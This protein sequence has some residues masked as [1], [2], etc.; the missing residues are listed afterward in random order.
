MTQL[1]DSP[2]LRAGNPLYQ[3]KPKKLPFDDSSEWDDGYSAADCENHHF[4]H[5]VVTALYFTMMI[6]S[7]ALVYTVFVVVRELI[8]SR[9]LKFN[10]TGT[11]L[12]ILFVQGISVALLSLIYFANN[13]GLDRQE[14]WYQ[15]R[16]LLF[17]V[18]FPCVPLID[19][20]IAVTW[21]DLYDRTNKMSKS[22]SKVI[23]VMR[24]AFRLISLFLA[25]GMS[26]VVGSGSLAALVWGLIGPN[27]IGW[28]FVAVGGLL[29]TKTLCPD[30][31]DVANPNWKVSQAIRR[32]VSH[33]LLGKILEVTLL[34]GMLTVNRHPQ[35]GYFYGAF[36]GFYIFTFVF[37]M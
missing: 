20:E 36:T 34:L 8:R 16:T 37:R 1:N 31:K 15:R 32:S 2:S 23:K 29:I 28:P 22:S 7:L 5:F 6:L 35:L 11:S 26:F 21:M 18:M 25:F 4:Q 27:V 3:K 24:V 19:F 30:N 14:Y 10:A 13:I 17:N 33:N 9:A 12:I